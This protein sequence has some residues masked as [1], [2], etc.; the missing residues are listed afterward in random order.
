MS[1]I[2]NIKYILNAVAAWFL[3]LAMAVLSFFSGGWLIDLSGVTPDDYA[4][5]K[6]VYAQ[7]LTGPD[8]ADAGDP[9]AASKIAGMA[10]WGRDR[11][12]ALVKDGKAPWLGVEKITV[13]SDITRVYA[14]ILAM[15]K[16]YACRGGDAYGDE[17]LLRDILYAL[18]WMY[19]NVYGPLACD[20]NKFGNWWDWEIG[21][22]TYLVGTLTL[23]EASV[24]RDVIDRYLVP[25]N[26]F[27]PLPERTSA[28]LVDA[29]YIAIG[30]AALQ[31]DGRRIVRSVRKLGEV[32]P[33]VETGDGFYAD[34][35]YVMHVDIPYQGG[36]GTIMLEGLSRVIL[37]LDSTFFAVPAEWTAAQARWAFDSFMPLMFRGGL[38]GMV[39]GRNIVRAVDD[40]GIGYNAVAGMLRMTKYAEPATARKLASAVKYYYAC[41]AERYDAASGLYDYCLF[42]ALAADASVPA[43]EAPRVAKAFPKMDRVSKLA[44]TYSVGISM[45]S[46]RI[47]KYEAINGENG[48][49]WYTGDGMLYV[50]TSPLDFGIDYWRSVNFY[51]MP[52]TTVTTRERKDMNITLKCLPDTP[53]AGGAAQ[54]DCAVAAM[55]L[56]GVTSEFPSTLKAKKAWFLFDGEIVALGADIV[57]HDAYGAETIIENR[58]LKPGAA[59]MADGVPVAGESGVLD[60]AKTLYIGGLGGIYLPG[61]TAVN[62][63]RVKPGPEFVELWLDH[64][65]DFDGASYAYAVLPAASPESVAAYAADPDIEILANFAAVQAVRDKR[66]GVTGYVFHRAGAFDGVAVDGA[67]IV[68]KKTTENTLALTVCD[69]AQE[70]GSIRVDVEAA[71]WT[72]AEKDANVTCSAGGSSVSVNVDASART[73]LGAQAVF[74]K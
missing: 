29:A 16:A 66:L 30:A 58:I 17:T 10:A 5:I 11:Q 23:I 26:R 39:R 73:G 41:N 51:R 64:G 61:D 15:A 68:I 2:T 21:S 52:G 9:A 31:Q 62:F 4:H 3:S 42:K 67:C 55:Q 63:R 43:M 56:L 71:G 59:F 57:C 8:E 12:A 65:K 25:V 14:N 54:G 36:Y 34:G 70:R 53:F 20:A 24:P 45:A 40:I 72:L 49:G 28:N 74:V 6:S 7:L 13:S 1:Q 48:K 22:P 46:R 35:S 69:P 18:E 19:R 37:A 44:E 50:Q 60:G 32:F 38:P 27:V 47:A 33:F